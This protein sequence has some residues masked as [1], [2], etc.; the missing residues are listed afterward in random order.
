MR[1]DFFM[2]MFYLSML[3]T[4]EEKLLI[5]Q[6]Y[7]QYR[8]MMYKISF[9][10]LKDSFD[11]ED[12]VHNTFIGII[13]SSYLLNLS[14][15]NSRETKAYIITAVKHSAIK[16]YN[17]RKSVITEDIDEHFELESDESVEETALSAVGV[18]E[19]KAA[20]S[21]LSD[22]D[23]E[24]LYLSVFGQK[25]NDEIAKLLEINPE[26]ARKKVYRARQRLA[27]KITEK[28]GVAV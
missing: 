14:D 6:L 2:F 4:P 3:E 11:A 17:K 26:T 10:I 12:A 27:Q 1:G 24:V 16:I 13:R 7:S 8:H 21:E 18:E 19:I 20:L 22:N 23:Y 25:S 28:R 15:V 9:S 5:E